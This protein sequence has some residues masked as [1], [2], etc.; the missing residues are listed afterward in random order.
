[1][2]SIKKLKNVYKEAYTLGHFPSLSKI[3]F[4]KH[5]ILAYYGFLGD[6]NFGDE[7]VYEATKKLFYPN[8]LLPVKSRMPLLLKLYSTLYKSKISGVVIG[9]GTLIGPIFLKGDYFTSIIK[10]GKPLYVHGTGVHKKEYFNSFWNEIFSGPFFGG[11]RGPLSVKNITSINVKA[12]IIGD[13]AF[14]LFEKYD[15]AQKGANGKSI[16]I[17][18][19]THAN[20]KD[21]II[22]RKALKSF[23]KHMISE[24]YTIQFLPFHSIDLDL[25]LELTS[26][27]PEIIILEIPNKY[28][29]AVQHF[30]SS[31]FAIGERLH[32]NVMAA[33]TK[34]PFMSINYTAKHEDFLLSIDLKDCGISPSEASVSLFKDAFHNRQLLDWKTIEN[35]ILSMKSRQLD[36]MAGFKNKMA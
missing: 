33:L 23:I 27:F 6:E 12:N 19:G 28:S 1:M 10:E 8:I 29:E 9:G 20:Y 15:W 2:N 21:L 35:K 22:S 16:L 32:F 18:L 24:G 13:A 30:L 34:C 26:D 25:G 36:E 5:K 31:S 14:Q 4:T 11:V 3:I 7:L 17:N